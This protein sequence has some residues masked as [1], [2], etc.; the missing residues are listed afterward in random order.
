[1]VRK[2]SIQDIDILVQIYEDAKK[3]M[4]THGNPNQWNNGHPNREDL[5]ADIDEDTLYVLEEDGQIQACFKFY[6]G[7]DPTYQYI[8][9]GQWLN[10]LPYGVIH[11]VATRRLKKGM[12]T[13]ILDACKK[14]HPNLKIDTHA[15]N[16]YM[17]RLLEKNNFKYV[18]QIYLEN[19]DP[20]RAYQFCTDCKRA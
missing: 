18:G 17:Q 7:E 2:A 10:D 15:D 12:G 13:K 9:H 8:D 19:G 14:F 6:I 3:F 20:R 1:M 4:H 5:L 16:I 11:R